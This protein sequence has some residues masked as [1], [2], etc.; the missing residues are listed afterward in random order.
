MPDIEERLAREILV[1][2]GAMGTMIMKAGLGESDFRGERFAGH[3]VGLKGCNDILCL[4]RPGLIRQIHR[5]YLDAGA[6]IVSTNT[7]N[8]NRLSLADYGVAG[9]AA[10]ICRAGVA[11]ARSAVDGFCAENNVPASRRP[12]VAGSIGPTGISLSIASQEDTSAK[13]FDRLADAVEEQT[14]AMILA[15]ADLLLLETVFDLLNAKAACVGISRAFEKTG[16]RLPLMVSATLTEQG[17]L[18]SGQSLA[19]FAATTGHYRPLSLGINCSFGASALAGRIGELSRLTPEYVSIHPNAGLPDAMGRYDCSPAKML[20]EMNMIMKSGTVNI[21]GG[22][23]GTTPEHIRMIARAARAIPPRRRPERKPAPG[24]F[25]KVGERCNV[26]GSRKFLRLAESRDWNEALDI[27]SSQITQGADMLDINMDDPMLDAA[28]SMAAFVSRLASDPRTASVPLM[29]DSSDFDVVGRTLRLIP[30]KGIVNSISLKNGEDEFLRRA[31]EINRLGCAMV[32]MAFDER[33]Q[34]STFERRVEICRR[35]YDLLT[36]RAGIPPE[37]II[38]D[39]NVLAVATGIATDETAA[40]D[41]I[42]TVGWI[43]RNLPG[44]HVS[45]GISNISFSFR[46]IDPLRRA[47]HS[48]FLELCVGQGMDMAIINPSTPLDARW[49]DSGLRALLEDLLLNRRPDATERLVAYAS[50]L[51]AKIDAGKAAGNSIPGVRPPAETAAVEKLSAREMLARTLLTGDTGGLDELIDRALKESG[52]SAMAVVNDALMAGMNRVGELFARGE[53]FLPQVVR[54]AAVM[55]QAVAILV[56]LIEAQQTAGDNGAKISRRRPL[57]VLATVKGDVH[58]IGKIIVAVVM[59]CSGFDILDLGVMTPPEE[60]VRAAVE[61]HAAAVGLSGL[62]TPSLHEMTRVA[63][64]LETNGLDI[65]LFVGG[66]TTSPLHTAVRIAPA[67]SGPV[68]HTR[69]AASLPGA[70]AKFT[71]PA[72]ASAATA[73]LKE[74]QQ[75]LRDDYKRESSPLSL[76]EARSRSAVVAEPSPVPLCP[77]EHLLK[78]DPGDVAGLVNWRAF[79]SEWGMDPNSADQ[80]ESKRLIDDASR[81]LIEIDGRLTAKVLILPAHSEGDDILLDGIV[82]IPTIRT[83]T[84]NPS[85]GKCLAMADFIHPGGDHI[86]LFC[87]TVAGSALPEEI[88]RAKKTDQYQ[89]LLLQSL[90]H[91]LAEAATEWTD[92]YVCQKLWG[93]LPKPGIRPA[94]GY[95][96]LPDQSLVSL[97]DTILDYGSLGI[98]VTEHGALSPSGTTT[99]LIIAHPSARYF[100]VGT[101]TTDARNDYARRRGLNIEDLT[102]YL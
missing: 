98:E 16:R 75:R 60:I 51:K 88:E 11:V 46:G 8:A 94:I 6:D 12:F 43:R 5:D 58:D 79:L 92:R 34:A 76:V 3:P 100:D 10:E 62:I 2:D 81:L 85:T 33:G 93:N 1:L 102:P 56:P 26:A 67:Y 71:D 38:F 54:S 13:P 101:M 73:E 64:M 32:V 15:G 23:C 74:T 72:T 30:L 95:S 63:S 45:G 68:I 36:I 80:P 53:L 42:R 57:M 41:F 4:T 7:F 69:D 24:G 31:R 27:A 96:S 20:V 49:V 91:R 14:A 87:V 70:V 19:D 29:I 47:M 77:G 22:C 82:R 66:A 25:T 59:R 39:P 86:G 35:A 65:P 97:F 78:I 90:S 17:R 37:D 52:G 55:K 21:V 44:A 99:G 28:E 89:S 40:L 61:N 83:Q 18:L 84:P 48:L 50:E 9:L